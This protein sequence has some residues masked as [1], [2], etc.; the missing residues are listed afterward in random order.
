MFQ[1]QVVQPSK[2][3][4]VI[5][6]V[7]LGIILLT[8]PLAGVSAAGPADEGDIDFTQFSL[9]ELKS[10]KIT[11]ASKTPKNLSEIPAAVF[12]ITQDDI[13]RSGA[14]SIPEA[15]RMAPGVEVARVSATEWAVNM[16]DLNQLF[17]NKLLVLMDG[18]SIYSHLASG[19][20][21]DIQ[22]TVL[23]DIDRIEVIRGPG[24]ALWG[25]NAVNGVINIITKKAADTQGGEVTALG[26]SE[27]GIGT[28]RYGGVFGRDS[29]YRIYAKYFDRGSLFQSDD[30]IQDDGVNSDWQSGRGG[31]RMEWKPKDGRDS[32]FLQGEVFKN[33]YR[34]EIPMLAPE[35]PHIRQIR[36][37]S[38]AKGGHMLSRWTRTFSEKSDSVLQFF[39][40]YYDKDIDYANVEASTF[41]LD[42]QHRFPFR[43]RHE[44]VWGLNYRLILDN[45]K[46]SEETI[47]DPDAETLQYYSAFVQDRIRIFDRLNLTL[48]AKFEH[49]DYTRWEIQPSARLLW[50]LD[51]RHSFWGAVSRAA[52]VPS[53]VEH[54]GI[55]QEVT[56][57]DPSAIGQ[58]P[59]V[60]RG[61]GDNGL[62]AETLVAYEAG[63]RFQPASSLWFDTTAFYNDYEDL[64]AYRYDH[65]GKIEVEGAPY[66]IVPLHFDNSLRGE[67]FGIELAAYWQATVF[68]LLQG[69]YTFLETNLNPGLLDT[70][71]D[72]TYLIQ[73]SNPRN[74]ISIRSALN[75]TSQ[76]ELDLWFRY[77]DRLNENDVD[78][79]ASLDARLA[80][81]PTDRLELSVVGQN[82]LEPRHAEFSSIEVERSIYLK[83]D[84]C[85]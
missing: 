75:I 58:V 41:D 77:V 38:R 29:H 10:V 36:D 85:F 50:N 80:Y 78:E 67:S 44:L 49:N 70:G 9:E 64:I 17:A 8:A 16:R 37:T 12:V 69:S 53:R 45:F 14:T 66:V 59:V 68:W 24:A 84:W 56:L 33:R 43:D 7:V 3:R 15:L 21:W 61:M 19:V 83:A 73:A 71:E 31:A 60:Y 51:E 40:D 2:H 57:P 82:L 72:E 11:S 26:G 32:V 25:V 28:L 79:Y 22:D 65:D 47:L 4:H 34:A 52:R 48:G 76:L 1:L 6:W 54:D 46:N 18:R 35:A 20:F 23:E 39:Y 5:R 63:Y 27:E 74:Q 81:R 42:F 30:P 62:N 55:V 13:R